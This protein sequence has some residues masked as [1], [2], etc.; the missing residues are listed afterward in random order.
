MTP[1]GEQ[2]TMTKATIG[3][4]R[5]KQLVNQ[6]HANIVFMTGTVASRHAMPGRGSKTTTTT[7]PGCALTPGQDNL[8]CKP[9]LLVSP[10]LRLTTTRSEEP[11]SVCN[12]APELYIRVAKPPISRLYSG[13]PSP[14]SS[15]LF[16]LAYTPHCKELSIQP[17]NAHSNSP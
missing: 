11:H 2:E 16:P 14:H 6:H 5:A 8:P 4:R 10:S 13:S 7:V 1:L 15:Y 9:S 3:P 12:M 17:R